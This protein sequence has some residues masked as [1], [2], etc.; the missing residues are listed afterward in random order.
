MRGNRVRNVT[1]VGVLGLLALM[2]IVWFFVLS[3]RLSSAD[4]ISAQADQLEM[5]NLQLRNKV[6][7]AQEQVKQAPA[8]AAEAQKLFATMP[9]AAELPTVLRQITDAAQRAGIGPADIQAIS[10]TVP[11][12]T[13]A[14]GGADASGVSMATMNIGV[15]VS[16]SPQDLLKFVDNL[17][18][19]D[20]AL[21]ITSTQES[22]ETDTGKDSMQVQ[23]RMFV[24]QS[25]LPDLVAQV[26]AL[27]EQANAAS[28]TTES[29][30]DEAATTPSTPA[31]PSPASPAPAG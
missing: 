22:T 15:T 5:A 21:L 29:T 23:G 20:R 3:P 26:E 19:L 25:Q 27:M 9:Q 12:A 2:A 24:L 31:S 17:Q 8:A 16:G 6:N 18:A 30:T 11:A 10:T 1:I 7:Q 28:A 13:G 14:A 4:E